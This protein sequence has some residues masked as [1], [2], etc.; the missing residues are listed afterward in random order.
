MSKY[1]TAAPKGTAV[2]PK[3]L[4]KLYEYV[5]DSEIKYWINAYLALFLY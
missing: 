1:F 2:D 4:E 3:A 5:L